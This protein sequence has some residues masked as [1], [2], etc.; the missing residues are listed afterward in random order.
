MSHRRRLTCSMSRFLRSSRYISSRCISS[1]GGCPRFGHR[2]LTPRP[3]TCLLNRLVW[4]V[5]PRLRFLEKVQ[6]ML[7][8]ISR[9]N[10]E[11]V[12]ICIL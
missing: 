12:M 4:T 10:C 9:P 7:R 3:S 1:S 5:V 6:Y 2:D 11:K 8:A